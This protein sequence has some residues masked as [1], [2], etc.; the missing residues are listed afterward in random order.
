VAVG[1]GKVSGTTGTSLFALDEATGR[2]LW[3]RRLTRTTT[4]GV[5]VQPQIIGREVIASSVP[6]G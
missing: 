3:T 6:S 5:D 1:F 4:D 2:K